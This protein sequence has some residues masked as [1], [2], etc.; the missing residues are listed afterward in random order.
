MTVLF[1]SHHPFVSRQRLD[2]ILSKYEV[3]SKHPLSPPKYTF[4]SAFRA[5]LVRK[6]R[7]YFL[8]QAIHRGCSMLQATKATPGRWAFCLMLFVARLLALYGCYY[9]GH[10][11]FFLIEPIVSWVSMSNTFHDAAH[12]ALST[13]PLINSAVANCYVDF[14]GTMDWYIQHNVGHHGSTNEAGA[15]PDLYHAT[16]IYRSHES[17]RWRP[18]HRW[19]RIVGWLVWGIAIHTGMQFLSPVKMALRGF[20]NRCVALPREHIH[21]RDWV[22]WVGAKLLFLVVY[23][24]MPLYHFGIPAGLAVFLLSRGIYSVLFMLHTQVSHLQTSC[25]TG[26]SDWYTHQVMTTT[27]HGCDSW[28]ATFLSGGLNYQIEHH[29]F[30]SVNHCHYPALRTMVQETCRVHDVEYKEWGTYREAL[31]GHLDYM[32]SLSSPTK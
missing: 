14:S 3:S 30:P 6:A 5:D 11:S 7:E 2:R 9:Y 22:Q 8:D 25:M 16:D 20:Y 18:I 29:L 17:V 12:F 31:R 21:R 23:A 10:L 27:N 28:W 24:G 15:D 4:D 19:V 1:E 32:H 13:N 26:S